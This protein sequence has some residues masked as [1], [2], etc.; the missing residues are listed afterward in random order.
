MQPFACPVRLFRF[1]G[2]DVSVYQNMDARLS[3]QILFTAF[4]AG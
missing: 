1:S 2:G 3:S 4:I